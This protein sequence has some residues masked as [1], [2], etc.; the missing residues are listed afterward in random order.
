[1]VRVVD[2]IQRRR[3][4]LLWAVAGYG[5]ATLIFGI[6]RSFWLTFFCLALTGVTD[7]REAW[8]FE[9]SSAR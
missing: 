4:V 1:M 8:C 5:L 2:H 3:S 7:H 6:S 9:T